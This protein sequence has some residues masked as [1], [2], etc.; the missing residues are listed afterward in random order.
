MDYCPSL[1]NEIDIVYNTDVT[2]L[3][4]TSLNILHLNTRSCRNKMDE[5]T[6]MIYDMKKIFH[7]IVF[8]ETWLYKEE[9][10]NI[11]DYTAYHSC[12]D[13]RGGGVSIFVLSNL[14][15]Q[16]IMELNYDVNNFLVIELLDLG[17][18]LMGVYNP[19]R[20]VGLFL[21]KFEQI[22]T[23]YDTLYICGDLI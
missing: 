3:S 20:N 7:V 13:D 12:R 17:I 10:C 9:I 15:S 18:K 22:I 23:N 21:D 16:L 19:G 14:R 5:L 1:T 2:E 4:N 8:S 6:Q 11:N